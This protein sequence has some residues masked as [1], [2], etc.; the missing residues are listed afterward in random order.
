MGETDLKEIPAVVAEGKGIVFVKNVLQTINWNAAPKEAWRVLQDFIWSTSE[1]D[2]AFVKNI[3]HTI[4]W[5][6]APEE[7]WV[8]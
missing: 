2:I 7:A 6:E 4:T 8:K 3:L 5:N 1:E